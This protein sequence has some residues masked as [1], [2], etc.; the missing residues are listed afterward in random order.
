MAN[1]EPKAKN[2]LKQQVVSW[3]NKNIITDYEARDILK[4]Y[5]IDYEMPAAKPVNIIRVL[6]IIGAILLGIGV[7]LFV[8]SN[9]HK[10]PALAK[11][12]ILL[13]T[14]FT[15]FCLAYFFSYQRENMQILGHVLFFLASLFY[16]GSTFLIAQTYHVNANA[17][18]LVFFWAASI[19]PVAFF[20]KSIDTY[21]LSTSLF[22][23]WGVMFSNSNHVPNYFYPPILFLVLIPLAKWKEIFN[24]PNY[25]GLAFASID[26][27][28]RNYQWLALEWA[29]A[30]LAYYL[31]ARHI[32]DRK[33]HF[34]TI[35]SG[36]FVLWNI[37]F[38]IS[39]S[40]LPNYFQLIP[41][42]A[43]YYVSYKEKDQSLFLVTTLGAII[44]ANL[45]V[46]TLARHYSHPEE[47]AI[48]T[49]LLFNCMLGVIIYL[50]GK[51]H[52]FLKMNEFATILKATGAL[53]VTFLVYALS[54]KLLLKEIN[55]LDKSVYFFS[56]II[57]T[58]A[59]TISLIFNLV[60]GAFKEKG[61][62]VELAGTA[63]IIILGTIA[64]IKPENYALNT[65]LFNIL[66]FGLAIAAI[67]YGFD[68]QSPAI[69]NAGVFL[70]VVAIITR[71]FDLFWGLLSRSLFFI[72]GGAVLLGAGIL[73]E[74]K[75]RATIES[76]RG[77]SK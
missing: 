68:A 76:M 33:N 54:F 43:L 44:W 3:K 40:S 59:A 20:F 50:L 28:V 23:L 5:G 37:S 24:I 35:A 18:W 29:V 16:G 71:Y 1:L 17:S 30:A 6:M 56:A 22:A 12:A 14:T 65:F 74:R 15:T 46:F 19:L 38:F 52:D 11:T 67:I 32:R 39:H 42:A 48:L 45:L 27:L 62:L 25:F 36:L 4:E 7:I 66:L 21:L 57:A 53:I 31:F 72:G 61:G 9:W 8:A 77:K 47:G 63:L 13:G 70:F 10:I 69:F 51:L 26:A 34:A 73:L 64:F 41:L 49:G 55:I 60:V 58:A 2:W 75:R